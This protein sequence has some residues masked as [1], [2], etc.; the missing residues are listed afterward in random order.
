MSYIWGMKKPWN[1]FIDEKAFIIQKYICMLI[2]KIIYECTF[3]CAHIFTCKFIIEIV[4][5]LLN[6][7]TTTTTFLHMG[8]L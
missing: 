3:S 1:N 6:F 8:V 7:T 5:V 4:H 2:L